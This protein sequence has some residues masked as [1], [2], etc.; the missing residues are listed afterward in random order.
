MKCY[1]SIPP[2][3]KAS[4]LSFDGPA[5]E[6]AGAI[7]T[8]P[9]ICTASMRQCPLLCALEDSRRLHLKRSPI[10]SLVFTMCPFCAI[11]AWGIIAFPIGCI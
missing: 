5:D 6:K 2:R 3:L 4:L 7:R 10:K 11:S 8:S 9:S 1:G